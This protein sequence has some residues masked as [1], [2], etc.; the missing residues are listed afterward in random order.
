MGYPIYVEDDVD[1]QGLADIEH[2]IDETSE[3][4]V[5]PADDIHL[6]SDFDF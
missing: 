6:P 3:D 2:G 1:I 5:D 4:W